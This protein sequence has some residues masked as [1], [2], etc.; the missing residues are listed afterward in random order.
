[1]CF[2]SGA[3]FG[4]VDPVRRQNAASQRREVIPRQWKQL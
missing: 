1:V 3:F 2:R 4:E